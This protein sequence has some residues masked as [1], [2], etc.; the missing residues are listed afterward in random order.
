V[1]FLISPLSSH[2]YLGHN[3][4]RELPDN[5][6]TSLEL[7]V[8]D[9]S[10]NYF[11]APPRGLANAQTISDLRLN[12]NPFNRLEPGAFNDTHGISTLELSSCGLTTAT[13]HPLALRQEIFQSL[14]TL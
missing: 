8:L 6:F 4:L 3:W 5:V 14:D 1:L 7:T 9:L 10:Y 2:R 12:N 11:S 13:L